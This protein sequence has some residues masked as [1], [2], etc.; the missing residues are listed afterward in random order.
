MEYKDGPN[1]HQRSSKTQETRAPELTSS[2][3]SQ[4]SRASATF[5]KVR[6]VAPPST[7][8]LTLDNLMAS[9]TQPHPP[10]ST[11]ATSPEAQLHEIVGHDQPKA[12]SQIMPI[13]DRPQPQQQITVAQAQPPVGPREVS[14]PPS[15]VSEEGPAQE[16]RESVVESSRDRERT[17]PSEHSRSRRR[18]SPPPRNGETEVTPDSPKVRSKESKKAEK[19]KKKG[20]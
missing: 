19:R 17:P 14:K 15:P 2:A 4:E 7:Q 18:H 5:E 3:Q 1:L 20:I 12:S 16:K 13:E 10:S 9:V 6:S 8:P 11:A